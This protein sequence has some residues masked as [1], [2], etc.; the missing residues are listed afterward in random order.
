MNKRLAIVNHNLGSGGAEKLIYDMALEL[1]NINIKFSIILLT[2]V[3]DIYGKKL[4]EAGIDV[5]YLSDKW[6]IYNPKN[7]FKLKKILKKYDVIHTHT[8]S[9]Q[10]WTAFASL[11]L[12]KNKKYITT[13]HSTSN[14]RRKKKIFK[15]LDKW[16]YRQYDTIVSITKNIQESL[17]LWLDNKNSSKYKIIKNGINLN[18]YLSV[19]PKSREKEGF[20]I[21]ENLI[22]MVGRF[23]EAKNHETLL[24]ALKEL[25]RSYKV[26]LAGEGEL[27]KKIQ[28]LVEEL[29]LCD[30]VKFLGYRSDIPEI[31]KMC[32]I[33]VL[34]S[35]W[36]GMPLSA[37]EIMA[38]EVP[39]LG[40]NVAGI[41]DL[42]N[43]KLMLFENGD[44][45]ELKEKI[46]ELEKKKELRD[47]IILKGKII[48]QK[49][50]IAGVIKSYI[51]IYEGEK[52]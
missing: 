36:E 10:L 5:V 8:Y 35:N 33:G 17:E 27:K 44:S 40:S 16:M 50:D 12:D 2:N 43:N 45:K 39:F 51:E 26:L 48:S 31:I 3:N 18:D 15:Y 22:I 9:A 41:K 49:Y 30:R 11:F 13:E 34:S 6:D 28:N 25:P 19:K 32:N 46:L 14:R 29:A 37:I 4:Q 1:K 7:I 52:K 38:L 23:T 47:E 42:V 21:E 20:V 24:K